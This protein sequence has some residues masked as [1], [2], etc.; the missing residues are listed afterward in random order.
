MEARQ[1]QG[2]TDSRGDQSFNDNITDF[3]EKN[4]Q[5]FDLIYYCR[6][7]AIYLLDVLHKSWNQNH[8]LW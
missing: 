4:H 3:Q 8:Q 6:L 7:S 1:Q 2:L 5:I